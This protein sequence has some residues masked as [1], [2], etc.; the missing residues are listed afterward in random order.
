MPVY[1]RLVLQEAISLLQ[2]LR[3]VPAVWRVQQAPSRVKQLQ[4]SALHVQPVPM[5]LLDR[6]AVRVVLQVLIR[7]ARVNRVVRCVQQAQ[8][9]LIQVVR[10]QHFVLNAT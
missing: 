8:L 10:L 9:I 4:A 6:R 3:A 2:V 5:L 1:V 7:P